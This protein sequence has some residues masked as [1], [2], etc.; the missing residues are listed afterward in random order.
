MPDPRIDRGSLQACGGLFGIIGKGGVRPR[1]FVFVSIKAKRV[2][3]FFQPLDAAAAADD[4]PQ[5]PE[6][7]AAAEEEPP[8]PQL[9]PPQLFHPPPHPPHP[10]QFP[11]PHPQVRSFRAG[12]PV[13]EEGGEAGGRG[14]VGMRRDGTR[15]A[16]KANLGPACVSFPNPLPHAPAAASARQRARH[17]ASTRVV[18][19]AIERRGNSRAEV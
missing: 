4:P 2:L 6:L 1:V 13:S 19:R 18:E 10:P 17:K 16:S 7:A 3:D 14:E 5:P 9:L 12:R 15:R 11:Q 8:P